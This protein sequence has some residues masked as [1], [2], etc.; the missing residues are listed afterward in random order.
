MTERVHAGDHRGKGVDQV[1]DQLLRSAGDLAEADQ[2]LIG[3]DFHQHDL[4]ALHAFMRGPARLGVG[5]R[6]RM[7]VDFGDLHECLFPRTVLT[8]TVNGGRCSG[9]MGFATLYPSYT[10]EPPGGP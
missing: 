7:G 9:L 6:Q 8:R 3:A 2:S 10:L 4:V 1:A 5:H